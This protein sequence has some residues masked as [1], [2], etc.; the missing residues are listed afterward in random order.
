MV[1]FRRYALLVLIALSSCSY[2]EMGEVEPQAGEIKAVTS[3]DS[4]WPV[5]NAPE[6]LANAKTDSTSNAYDSEGKSVQFLV[7]DEYL[8][9]THQN[10]KK[11][12]VNLNVYLACY[13]D[14]WYPVR[15]F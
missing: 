1:D 7:S 12:Y 10:C 2:L 5:R 8:S 3:F 9:A 11:Y 4:Q 13:S 14:N 6:L 15:A